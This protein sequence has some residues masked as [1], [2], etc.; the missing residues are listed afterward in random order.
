MLMVKELMNP[1]AH[2]TVHVEHILLTNSRNKANTLHALLKTAAVAVKYMSQEW[3][4]SMSRQ[5]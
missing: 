5:L 3:S 4:T 1:A 2:P